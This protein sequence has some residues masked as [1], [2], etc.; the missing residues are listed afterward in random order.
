MSHS[1]NDLDAMIE[2]EKH[3]VA[4]EYQDEAWAGGISDGIDREIMA[5]AAIATGMRAMVAA[6]GEDAALA[7]VEELR[8]KVVAG[9]FTARTLQ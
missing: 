5:D 1:K 6:V 8:E 9:E 7:Y 2:H 3:Q 4:L